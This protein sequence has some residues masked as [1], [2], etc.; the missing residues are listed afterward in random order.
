M[1]ASRPSDHVAPR[2]RLIRE[3]L[4][5]RQLH[6]T[7]SKE[8]LIQ[9]LE[10]DIRQ[11]CEVTPPAKSN[12]SAST[13]AP[14]LILDQVTVQSLALLFQQLLCPAATITTLPDLSSFIA[15]FDG[16][17]SHNANVSLDDI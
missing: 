3:E 10:A 16:S 9:R 5:R 6:T 7:S 8:D 11:R 12:T 1:G 4:A 14:S 15:Q 17:Q 2:H 13:G